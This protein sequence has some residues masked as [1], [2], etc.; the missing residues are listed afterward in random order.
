MKALCAAGCVG[1]A[2]WCSLG[3]LGLTLSGSTISRL[4]LLPPWWVLPLLIA[5]AFWAIRAARLIPTQLD[6]LFGAGVTIVPWLPIPLPPAAL[7][8]IGPF[9][10]AVWAVVLAGVVAARQPRSQRAWT[11]NPRR[12]PLTAAAIAMVLYAVSA[13]WLAPVL[14]DGDAPHYLILAQSLV[15]DGDIRIENNHRRGDYLEYSLHAERPHYLRRGL[16]GE[17]YSIHAPG[18]PAVIAPAYFLFGY[19]GS[20]G[21]L[22]LV[23]AAGTGLLWHLAYRTTGNVAAAWF[24][25]ATS[26][27]TVP[28][29]FQATQV[30]PD[31]LAATC[32][33]LGILP[34][35]AARFVDSAGPSSPDNRR[36]RVRT[37]LPW[38]ASGVA[39]ALLPW[40]QTRL[41]LVAVS[42]GLLV[43]A[44]MRRLSQFAL[45]AAVPLASAAAW[46]GFFYVVYGTI[47]PA[48]PY[49]T[50]TQT[51]LAN[52]V[53]GGPGLLLDQQFGLVPNAPVYG[54]VLLGVIA[55][56]IRLRR[57]GW[58]WLAILVPYLIG[59]GLFQIWWGGTSAPARLV[60]PVSLALGIAASWVWHDARCSAT[61]TAALMAL[62]AS[63]VLAAVLAIPG[64]GSLLLN[65]RDGVALWL[66]WGNDLI[67]VPRGVPSLFRDTTP[68]A[69]FKTAIWIASLGTAWF[70]IR[71]LDRHTPT[72]R[73]PLLDWQA[74]WCFAASV[75]IAFTLTWRVD[76]TRPLTPETANLSLLRGASPLRLV[77]FDYQ[78]FR[79]EPSL[80]PLSRIRINTDRS[81]RGPAPGALF[82]MSNVPAG[83]Y[84]AHV[85]SAEGATGSVRL[86]VGDTQ[87]PLWTA[88]LTGASSGAIGTPFTIPI[89]VQSLVIE[90]DGAARRTATGISLVPERLEQ[91]KSRLPGSILRARR[92]AP[93]GPAHVYFMDDHAYPEPTGFWVAG[94]RSARLIVTSPNSRLELFLRNAPVR[95]TVTIDAPGEHREVI[96][97]PGEETAL[98]FER[99]EFARGGAIGVSVAS[100]FRPSQSDPSNEDLRYLGC[101]IEIR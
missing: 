24:G 13:W 67:D 1:L 64:R 98:A 37:H 77:A 56:T 75:T 42:A 26:A 43:C 35:V 93:Y 28:F 78:R 9:A 63:V 71:I 16:N 88:T 23:A 92:A 96:L 20:V 80:S 99:P 41:A 85:A 61:K 48:A 21:F 5:G 39:L 50:Y 12:A 47:N 27:L 19:P 81:R 101:W 87:L 3:T 58:E 69:W 15:R 31:G 17:I 97:E 33:L 18:L 46:F 6:V 84:Q 65:F 73:R 54:A 68:H 86:R 94:G 8:W 79:F 76:G 57:W 11:A 62:V 70:L 60:A 53:R 74:T 89:D 25:W 52:L 10:L 30:F 34:L 2:A 14:P 100:G 95:N 4:A 38:L 55:A 29:F 83:T 49:G 66:E 32:V 22:A 91:A 36:F 72:R 44:R 82:A 59:V 51:A 45:F 40:L 90:G 7:L